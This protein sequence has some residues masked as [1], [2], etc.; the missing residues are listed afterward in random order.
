MSHTRQKSSQT[1]EIVKM[2]KEHINKKVVDKLGGKSIFTVLSW[3]VPIVI[4]VLA[5]I[6]VPILAQGSGSFF[7]MV[8][9]AYFSTGVAVGSIAGLLLGVVALIRREPYFVAAIPPVLFSILMLT[10]L[11]VFLFSSSSNP[12]SDIYVYPP[13][14]VSDARSQVYS[15][16]EIDPSRELLLS[17]QMTFGLVVAFSP[18]GRRIIHSNF[19]E[20]NRI[21]EGQTVLVNLETGEDLMTLKCGSSIQCFSFSQDGS[22]ALSGDMGGFVRIW[23]LSTGDEIKSNNSHGCYVRAIACSPTEELAISGDEKGNLLL[24]NLRDLTVIKRFSGHTSAI[25][26]NCLVWSKDGKRILSGSWDGS[27]RLWDVK[28]GRPLAS[29]NPEYGRVMSIAISPDGTRALSSYLNGPDQP[30]IFWDLE[31]QEELNRFGVPGNPWFADRELHVASVAFLPDGN[32]ALFGCVFGSVILWDLDQW[33]QI[34]LNWLHKKELCTVR[35]S[36]DGKTS[37]SIGCDTDSV[38]EPPTI[39]YWQLDSKIIPVLDETE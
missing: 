36:L 4:V 13:E 28:E 38:H 3:A 32:K 20:D 8:I 6:L 7:G 25:R 19:N 9:M 34:S 10:G 12:K 2:K 15:T 23:D 11:C 22:L 29:I 24:W 26:H 31:T 16:T 18:D 27:I 1:S 37:I 5:I 33:Q 39:K 30:V 17:D 35:C 21:T 14:L